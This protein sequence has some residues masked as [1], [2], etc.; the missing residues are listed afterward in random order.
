MEPLLH[1]ELP[2]NVHIYIYADDI[3]IVITGN[4]RPA[5]VNKTLKKINDKIEE[6]GL[7]I[8]TNKKKSHRNKNENTVSSKTRK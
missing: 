4:I 2:N 8:N 7:K 3:T 5:T 1:I 6:L